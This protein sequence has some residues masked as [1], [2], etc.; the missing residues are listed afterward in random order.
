MKALLHILWAS[1]AVTSV[2][3]SACSPTKH[4]VEG[5][6]LLT[7]NKVIIVPEN[8]SVRYNFTESDLLYLIRPVPNSKLFFMRIG[9]RFYA[10][11]S[12]DAFE[13]AV[14]KYTKKKERIDNRIDKL[15]QKN[16]E[17]QENSK[18]YK[19]QIERIED[20]EIKS[21]IMQQWLHKRTGIVGQEMIISEDQN[22]RRTYKCLYKKETKT[23]NLEAKLRKMREERDKFEK[24]SSEYLTIDKRLKKVQIKRDKIESKDCNILHW[25]RKAGEAPVLFKQNDQYRNIRQINIYL[26]NKG[27]Y[28][29]TVRVKDVPD[30][31]K[32]RKVIYTVSPN[33]PYTVRSFV[34]ESTDTLF[35]K[36]NP[37]IAE[38]TLLKKDILLDVSLLESERQ[39]IYETLRNKGYYKF[40]KDYIWFS[41]DTINGN[42]TSDIRMILK[43]PIENKEII[44]HKQYKIRYVNIYPNYDPKAALTDTERYNTS[45]DTFVLGTDKGNSF[46]FLRNTDDE[47]KP[48]SIVKGIYVFSD[49]LYCTADVKATYKY[50]S[51]MKIIKIANIDFDEIVI[52]KADSSYGYLDCNI[53]LTMNDKQSFTSELEATNTSGDIGAA[54]NVIYSHKN[55]FKN[56]ELLDVKLKGALERKAGSQDNTEETSL[57]FFN[58]YEI[59]ADVSL[60]FPRLFA[61]GDMTKFIKKNNPKTIINANLNLLARPDYKR[62]VAGLSFGYFWNTSPE[63]KHTVRP[64]LFDLVRLRNPSEAFLNYINRYKLY[65]SYEDHLILGSAYSLTYQTSSGNNSRNQIYVRMNGKIAGNSLY[66][67]MLLSGQAKTDGAYKVAGNSF[68]QFAKLD[69]DFRYYRKTGKQNKIVF[70]GFLGAIF[71]YGNLNVVP[72]GEKYYTGG[73]NGIRA[74][75]VRTLGPGSYRLPVYIDVFPNQTADIKG[76]FNIEYRQKVFW[77]LEGAI[78]VDAGNIWAINASDDR[79]GAIFKFNNFYR[80]IAV[81]TGVGFRFDFDFFIFRFDIGLKLRDPAQAPGRRMIHVHRGIQY[82]DF[83]F[84]IGIGYPF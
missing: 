83:A 18:A 42:H 80:E 50:L 73:A 43:Q 7:Q 5:Q 17:T 79:T 23:E 58:S 67:Y 38:N 70:R 13:N 37:D 9:T 33:T 44:S 24:N 71:P 32:K 49:S 65:E 55:I 51:S 66:A 2:M 31:R 19:K 6:Y 8:D 36:N 30:G 78:F 74:W 64:L 16:R 53:R 75:Q 81:G 14:E 76:E 56:A 57:A 40:S 45:M 26:K 62:E 61:P 84:N 3:I 41:I 68:A 39:R 63:I 1:L 69:V 29:S 22:F 82:N 12:K 54:G 25:T 34:P 28:T 20:L 11:R 27:F 4:L 60:E 47:L 35:M 10:L 59:G 15:Y 48:A 72:F 46:R 77:L 52:P 21:R